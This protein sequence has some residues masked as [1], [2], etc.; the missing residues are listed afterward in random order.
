MALLQTAIVP[1]V[2][3]APLTPRQVRR[4][5]DALLAAGARIDCAGKAK[6]RPEKLLEQGHVPRHK[7]ELFGMRFYLSGPRQNPLLRFLVAYVVPPTGSP[8]RTR[9]YPRIF[10]KDISLIWRSASHVVSTRGELWIGKGD[11]QVVHHD[12]WEMTATQEHTTDLPVELQDAVELCA[13]SARRIP[14]DEE[15]LRQVLRNAP[16]HRIRPYADFTGPR[17]RAAAERANLI[18]GGECVAHFARTHDPS[19]LEFVPGFEPD[20]RRGIL[21]VT[22]LSSSTY[23]GPL[24]RYRILSRNR[25][26]QYLFCASQQHVWIIPPQA[27]TTE[28]SSY[29][30]RTIDVCVEEELCL[31]GFEYHFHEHEDDPDSLHTQIP[32]GFAGAPNAVDPDRADASAWIEALPVVKQFRREVL[33]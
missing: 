4:D 16:Q 15:V 7:L 5:F 29:G 33:G 14:H 11:V 19:S 32:P 9:I 10:Y 2:V 20:F 17:R 22:P 24:K 18:H 3:P 21:S 27:L 23:G 26:I 25:Q 1:N 8:G 30:L 12:G 13:R 31:P 6:K 28:L